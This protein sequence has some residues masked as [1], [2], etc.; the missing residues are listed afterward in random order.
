MG[1]RGW[2]SAQ[3]GLQLCQRYEVTGRPD[4][5]AQGIGLLH[6]GLAKTSDPGER[7]L[8]LG[9]LGT[10]LWRH[11]ELTGDGAVLDESIAV[12]TA[13]LSSGLLGPEDFVKW[14][15]DLRHGLRARYDRTG[16]GADL[17]AAIIVAEQVRELPPWF[18]PPAEMWAGW[19]SDY[20]ADLEERAQL[21]APSDGAS[22]DPAARGDIDAAVRLRREVMRIAPA[23]YPDR[24]GLR[25]SLGQALT[26]RAVLAGPGAQHVGVD[27]AEA[28]DLN[29][30]AVRLAPAAHP[31]AVRLSGNLCRA[32]LEQA[33]RTGD[34]AL[35]DEAVTAAR[36]AGQRARPG[37]E[38]AA[39]RALLI[40]CLAR[41][42]KDAADP[43]CLKELIDA[44][45]DASSPAADAGEAAERRLAAAEAWHELYWRTG[46]P[47]SLTRAIEHCRAVLSS[48]DKLAAAHRDSARFALSTGLRFR[49]ERA[50][51]AADLTEAT[52]L[53]RAALAV[54][55]DPGH[56]ASCLGHLGVCLVL[57]AGSEAA[58]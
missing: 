56:R 33:E 58:G 53:A 23:G 30:E 57:A 16:R 6:G 7:A 14:T 47:A 27:L 22:A 8:I 45:E 2:R 1:G 41:R 49:F 36:R 12:R 18:R 19:L 51:A 46:D 32:L 3:Q 26:L 10:A 31:Y 34:R 21:R 29:R 5:L 43:A 4:D 13:A 55:A 38:A 39:T 9:N 28:V 50:R 37:E 44:L 52:E 42:A 20:A 35:L 48:R 11:F 17:D 25:S 54:A 24:P 40:M 15:H